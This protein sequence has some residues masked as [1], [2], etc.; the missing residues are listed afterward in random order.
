MHIDSEDEFIFC[1]SQLLVTLVS[2][3]SLDTM[4]GGIHFSGYTVVSRVLS[5][6]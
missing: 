3:V 6:C 5:E 2:L 1:V 4:L